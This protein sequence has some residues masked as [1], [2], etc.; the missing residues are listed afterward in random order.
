MRNYLKYGS[1]ANTDFGII[2]PAPL[3]FPSPM[4]RGEA[5]DIPGRDG[6]L[7]QS[8]GGAYG[9]IEA[10]VSMWIPPTADLASVRTWISGAR[11]LE[12]THG[13]TEYYKARVS[14]PLAPAPRD[15]GS[16]YDAV[17]TFAAE[18]FA[19]VKDAYGI[20]V[21]ASS[22]NVQNPYPVYALPLLVIDGS[23]DVEITVGGTTFTLDDLAAPVTLDCAIPECYDGSGPRNDIMR[24]AFPI[25]APGDNVVSWTGNVSSITITPRW[26]TL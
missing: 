17:V 18:P 2:L 15:F 8:D 7:W 16:G 10:A 12:I 23:G 4:E 3:V 24:G 20:S 25:L 5:I 21:T 26:R 9:E 13:A 14:S 22:T 19:Y 1:Y 11:N 6:V